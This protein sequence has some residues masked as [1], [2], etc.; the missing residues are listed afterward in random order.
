MGNLLPVLI[1]GITSVLFITLPISQTN[2]S[3][4]VENIF[5]HSEHQKEK[6]EK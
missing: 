3:T 2:D 4:L 6:K 5:G 1:L